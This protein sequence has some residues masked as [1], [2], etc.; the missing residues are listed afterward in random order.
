MVIFHFDFVGVS[1][2]P[3]EADSPLVIHADTALTT[4]ITCKFFQSISRRD[5]QLAKRFGGIQDQQLS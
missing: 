2:A 5:T 3:A 4:T 1:P